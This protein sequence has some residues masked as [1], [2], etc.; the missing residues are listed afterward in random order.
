[1]AS[2]LDR[3]AAAACAE[4]AARF[5]RVRA[6]VDAG[7][8]DA[9]VSQALRAACP[10]VWMT[11]EDG[12]AARERVAGTLDPKTVLQLGVGGEM[13][14][15]DHQFEVVVLSAAL[16]VGARARA[17]AV[18]RETHRILQGGGCLVFSVDESGAVSGFG[19]RGIVWRGGPYADGLCP[20]Q[21]MAS[22][23]GADRG[24]GDARVVRDV[25]TPGTKGR[26]EMKRLVRILCATAVALMV[27]CA[28]ADPANAIM[29]LLN[30]QASGSVR[31]FEQA[32]EEVAEQAKKGRP[33]YA[34]VLAL[35]SRMPSPPPAARLDDATRTK[36]LDGCRD[37]IKKL[38]NEKNNSMAWYLLSLENN[39]RD[40][41]HRAADAGNVQAMNAWG[42]YLVTRA[43]GETAET[44]ST[45][46]A[47]ATCAAS[48]RR[49]TT[50]APS[51]AS[52]PRRRRSIPRPSTTS[53]S[54]S[55]RGAW[56]RRTSR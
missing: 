34:Y 45:T 18:V 43:V 9:A 49:R 47:C 31:G 23:F 15:D 4:L 30:S 19:Q 48:A 32:A 12:V 37:K 8:G 56:W 13:P 53:G 51:T 29:R 7:F 36:Y 46:S 35:V 2:S 39:D 38:A 1:M 14:F 10:G 33:V 6:G 3:C 50:R 22:S 28:N 17:E 27:S 20:P 40:L 16:L 54:S 21:D 44:A 42:T 52:A 25:V 55:A 24:R 5:T 11:V 41:L 26:S